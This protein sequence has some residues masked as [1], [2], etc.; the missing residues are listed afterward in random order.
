MKNIILIIVGLLLLVVILVLA[1]I[2]PKLFPK[3]QEIVYVTSKVTISSS[4][5]SSPSTS[6]VPIAQY[7]LTEL[8]S[9]CHSAITGQVIKIDET[10]DGHVTYTI[11][12]IKVYKGRN[13]TSLGTVFVKG[14]TCLELDSNYLFLANVGEGRYEKYQYSEPF[15]NAPW[16][17]KIQ[18]D[19]D[20][21]THSSNGDIYLLDES[22]S[23]T[24]EKIKKICSGK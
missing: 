6:S 1:F 20:V 16:I 21:L 8:V 3:E 17:F 24:L 15:E 22:D 12:I 2:A 19:N 7:T 5:V 18:E 9:K 13:Y 11:N 14:D 4:D 10:T 23:I